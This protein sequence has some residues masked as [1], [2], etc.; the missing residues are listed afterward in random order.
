MYSADLKRKAPYV[1]LIDS[2]DIEDV[3]KK[4]SKF[5]NKFF[6]PTLAAY[7]PGTALVKA[8]CKTLPNFLEQAQDVKTQ[9]EL[10]LIAKACHISASAFKIFQKQL[11]AGMTEKQGAALLENIMKKLGGQGLAFDTMRPSK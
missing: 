9:S 10:K 5:K 2:L 6:D 1:T 4:A 8:G 3:C 7:I 11:K